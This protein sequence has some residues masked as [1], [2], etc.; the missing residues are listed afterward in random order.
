VLFR[1]GIDAFLSRGTAEAPGT[2][3]LSVSGRVKRPGLYE[4]DLGTPLSEV[5][6]LAGGGVTGEITAVLAGGP[7]GGFLAPGL[8]DVSLLPGLLHPT[9]AVTGSGGIV[10]L[11][12][13]SDIRSAAIA[14][15]RFNAEESCGKCTPCR[16]GAPRAERALVTGQLEGLRDLLDVVGSAS[17]CGLGQMAPGPIRSAL[18]FWPELFP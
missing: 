13:S 3:L 4:V 7:S 18:H 5:L 12:A 2:K 1:E 11:D 17:L 6:G 10:V 8:F 9:G 14:M 15:A 16:E